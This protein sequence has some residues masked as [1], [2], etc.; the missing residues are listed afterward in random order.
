MTA[1]L[2]RRERGRAVVRAAE[3]LATYRADADDRD[4]PL[5]EH[6]L[7]A[8]WLLGPG[9]LPALPWPLLRAGRAGRGPGPDVREVTFARDGVP[10]SGDVELHLRAS[11]F[12]RH[13]HGR[14]PVVRR[15]VLHVVWENDLDAEITLANGVTA[16]T[17]ALAPTLRAPSRVRTLLRRGPLL[18][19]PCARVAPPAEDGGSRNAS[20]EPPG[21]RKS[22]AGMARG[23][24]SGSELW[25]RVRGGDPAH[26]PTT[27]PATT[28]ARLGANAIRGRS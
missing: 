19:P 6:E 5:A 3:A 28:L 27:D 14:D 23:N 8:L 25:P 2:P 13:G 15:V 26:L 24:N 22:A 4:E 10:A 9:P 11:D 7:T 17:V 18:A 1:P 12:Y 21:W 20:G 16:P